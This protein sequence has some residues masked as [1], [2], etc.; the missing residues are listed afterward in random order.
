MLAP[1]FVMS[2]CF[3]G[4]LLDQSRDLHTRYLRLSN[5]ERCDRLLHL[6]LG[7]FMFV[8]ALVATL[9]IGGEWGTGPG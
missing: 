8:L 3:V 7:V 1:D 5:S 6:P 9:H 2:P 4:H